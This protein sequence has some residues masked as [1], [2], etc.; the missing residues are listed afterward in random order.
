MILPTLPL[1]ET[2]PI[3]FK[4][5]C[6]FPFS[7]QKETTSQTKETGR[8]REG[9]RAMAT[10]IKAILWRSGEHIVLHSCHVPWWI[11]YIKMLKVLNIHFQMFL[12]YSRKTF[13]Q[14]TYLFVT[15]GIYEKRIDLRWISLSLGWCSSHPYE[16]CCT[17][18]FCTRWFT[19]SELRLQKLADPLL[20]APHALL[21]DELYYASVSRRINKRRKINVDQL[22]PQREK[23][24]LQQP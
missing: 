11:Q 15:F 12:A 9:R 6:S 18:S 23:C 24:I 1:W 5:V 4:N 21:Y 14:H 16:E 8:R 7:H 3:T 22:K 13:K 19:E 10:S 2:F 17:L 20:C